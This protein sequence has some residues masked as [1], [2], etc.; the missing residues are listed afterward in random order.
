M[1]VIVIQILILLMLWLMSCVICALI[2]FFVAKTDWFKA[3]KKN[4]SHDEFTQVSDE[5]QRRREREER[6]Y[7][8]MMNYNGTPQEEIK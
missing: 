2:G 3:T 6:E 8:N 1:G 4:G 7:F 5:Q